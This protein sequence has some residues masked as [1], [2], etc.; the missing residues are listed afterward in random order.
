MVYGLQDVV[1]LRQM[2]DESPSSEEHKRVERHKLDALLGWC[3]ATT[4]RRQPCSNIS[5]S[6]RLAEEQ[7][8]PAYVIFADATLQQMLEKRPQSLEA[9]RDISGVGDRKL[10]LYGTEFLAVL[11]QG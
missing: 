11:R 4:C 10:E 8:V 5:A 7:N 6:R 2:V 9:L 1:R 3:E